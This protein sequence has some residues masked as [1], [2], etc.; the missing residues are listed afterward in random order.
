MFA[1]GYTNK[2]KARYE[3]LIC[4]KKSYLFLNNKLSQYFQNLMKQNLETA[5]DC[6]ELKNWLI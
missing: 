1:E 2:T 5:Q 4:I 3:K 6:Y